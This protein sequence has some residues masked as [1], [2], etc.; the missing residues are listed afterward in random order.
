MP[1]ISSPHCIE[2]MKSVEYFREEFYESTLVNAQFLTSTHFLG[3][4]KGV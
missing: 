2:H 1:Y 3:L 4:N